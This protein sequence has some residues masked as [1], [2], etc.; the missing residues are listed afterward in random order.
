MAVV[1]SG[2]TAPR[3]LATCRRTVPCSTAPRR[4]FTWP[5]R[6]SARPTRISRQGPRVA[7]TKHGG[8]ADLSRE[9][10]RGRPKLTRGHRTRRGWVQG[11]ETQRAGSYRICRSG[12]TSSRPSAQGRRAT[13]PGPGPSL[14]RRPVPPDHYL[15]AQPP[16]PGRG[17][18][19]PL[20]LAGKART[21]T[22]GV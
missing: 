16:R 15:K 6:I 2:V 5:T 8:G 22:G 7:S 19:P 11:T 17:S 14:A 10:P 9:S 12:R 1:Y 20:P 21:H 13:L 4:R 18:K 3:G